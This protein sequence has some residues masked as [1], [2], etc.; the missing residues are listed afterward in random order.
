MLYY[1][2]KIIDRYFNILI[3]LFFLCIMINRVNNLKLRD[4]FDNLKYFIKSI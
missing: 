3:L 1:N 4:K 2:V